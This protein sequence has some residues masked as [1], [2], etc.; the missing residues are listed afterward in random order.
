MR[1]QRQRKRRVIKREGEGYVSVVVRFAKPPE[2]PEEIARRYPP[3]SQEA[4]ASRVRW[5]SGVRWKGC[6]AYSLLRKTSRGTFLAVFGGTTIP[7]W[8]TLLRGKTFARGNSRQ[9]KISNLRWIQGH[10]NVSMSRRT[11][12]VYV[13]VYR[14]VNSPTISGM[15]KL[16]TEYRHFDFTSLFCMYFAEPF[17]WAIDCHWMRAIEVWSVALSLK[18]I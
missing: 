8:M 7:T 3:V 9:R 12:C 14:H 2:I 18:Y 16:R 6:F 15:D 1:V 5:H 10:L 17:W 4:P 13:C 11:L